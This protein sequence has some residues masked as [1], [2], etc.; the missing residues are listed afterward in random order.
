[1]IRPPAV[2]ASEVAASLV[3]A[4]FVFS[5]ELVTPAENSAGQL[6]TT[7]AADVTS[8]SIA[9]TAGDLPVYV[10]FRGAMNFGKGTATTGDRA[11]ATVLLVEDGATVESTTIAAPVPASGTVLLPFLIPWRRTPA[12]GEHTYKVQASTA[13]VATYTATL[14]AAATAKLMLGCREAAF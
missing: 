2:A 3:A 4:G 8:L 12:A 11:V 1:M 10:W 5:R 9:P 14:A 6:L 13:S 7:S